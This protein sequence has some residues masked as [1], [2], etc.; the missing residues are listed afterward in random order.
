MSDCRDSN[1]G[2]IISVN[3]ACLIIVLF[4]LF[5]N[6]SIDASPIFNAIGIWQMQLITD[7]INATILNPYFMFIVFLVAGY[8]FPIVWQAPLLPF[9]LLNEWYEKRQEQKELIRNGTDLTQRNNQRGI[10][11]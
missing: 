8:H 10:T 2:L 7:P 5:G 11:E 3:F 9:A 6:I 1:L 4:A